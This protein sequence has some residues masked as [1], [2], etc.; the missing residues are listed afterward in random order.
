MPTNVSD[1]EPSDQF[2]MP[3]EMMGFETVPVPTRETAADRAARLALRCGE[4]NREVERLSTVVRET[5]GI[6]ESYWHRAQRAEAKARELERILGEL[7]CDCDDYEGWHMTHQL[8]AAQAKLAKVEAER[9]KMREG[10]YGCHAHD[11]A[12]CATS[13]D[14]AQRSIVL[15]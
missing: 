5:Q 14:D 2:E 10:C 12:V 11:R 4:L 1:F 9:D 15:D 7:A 13:C 8:S 3:A 6:G